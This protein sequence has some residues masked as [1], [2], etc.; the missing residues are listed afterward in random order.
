V[1]RF[2]GR[3]LP[4]VFVVLALA[5]AGYAISKHGNE[6]GTVF[7]RLGV[8][9]LVLS[10][11]LALG[12][13]FLTFLMWRELLRGLGAPVPAVQ[14]SRVFFVSQLGKYLPGSIWPVVAQMEYGRRT[15][16]G[17]RTMLTANA[18]TVALSLAAGLILAAAV[19]PFSSPRALQ[20][21]WWTFACLPLLL[22]S[23]HPRVIP[24]VLNWLFR[25]IGR[26]PVDQP[27]TWR[28][29]L[30]ATGWALGAWLLLGLHLYVLVYAVG[31]HGLRLAAAA[32][33]GFVLAACAGILFI[34]AP[35]GAG[36][37]DAVLIATLA[38][39]LGD[40]TALALDLASRVLLIIVDIIAAVVATGVRAWFGGPE[41][42]ATPL[43]ARDD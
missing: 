25:R 4:Y 35:A 26:E 20:D 3:V 15:G 23:L 38:V 29:M 18:L 33:G 6:L 21:Y 10:T 42:G 22:I 39:S 41:V 43:L 7:H 37:R 13:V 2:L 16:T 5:A 36:V 30:R 14:A 8:R 9:P 34:P 28:C 31:G 12:G 11:L 24:G 40:T 17:R 1:K 19:L 32:V 27:L